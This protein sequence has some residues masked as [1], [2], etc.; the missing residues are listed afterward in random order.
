MCTVVHVRALYLCLFPIVLV[1]SSLSDAER[2]LNRIIEGDSDL[3]LSEDE[4]Q[5]GETREIQPDEKPDDQDESANEDDQ[6]SDSGQ[7]AGPARV[8]RRPLWAKTDM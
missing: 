2:I 6:D 4:T 7:D 5:E 8:Q 3:D 1:N